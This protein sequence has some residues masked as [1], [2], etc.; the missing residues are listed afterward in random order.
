M[1][2]FVAQGIM[3]LIESTG[4]PI[5]GKRAVIIGRSQL[6]GKPVSFML[7]ENNATVSVCHTH[8]MNLEKFTRAA[9]ILI[10]A[11]GHPHTVGR[12]MVKEGAIVIDV[13]VNQIG[14]RLVGDVD[15]DEVKSVAGWITPVPGG[16][17]PVTIAT[18][19]HNLVEAA[20]IY[21]W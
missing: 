6:V 15:Y 7:L 11:A 17:G 1:A 3:K 18:L 9:D 8:T 20:K 13:G 2:P 5:E 12:K 19:L 21:E 4:E 14:T 10:V 16:L